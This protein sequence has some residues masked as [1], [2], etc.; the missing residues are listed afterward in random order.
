MNDLS[1]QKN[2]V[3]WLR[4]LYPV[5]ALVGMFSIMYVPSELIVKNDPTATLAQIEANELLFRFGITGKLITQLLNIVAVWLLYKLFYTQYKDAT[6]M[7]AVLAFLG[8]PMDMLS[9]VNELMVMEIMDDAEQAYLFL[10]LSSRGTIIASI[11]WGLW[12][13]PMGYMI[14]Q[15]PLFPKII[16]WLVVVAGAGYTLAAFTFFMGIQGII[17]DI[18]E[19]LTIGE[20][21]WMI[22]LLIF[23]AKWKALETKNPI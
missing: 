20:V 15:S 18:L 2:A 22:W 7:M 1:Q 14:I 5:W 11:F 19:F 17:V 21:L 10:Q 6:I 4:I 13:L 12:L 9:T 3:K 8:I 23:G 16:G